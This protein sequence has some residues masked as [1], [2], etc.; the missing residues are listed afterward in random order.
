[1]AELTTFIAELGVT[2]RPT[3]LSIPLVSAPQ[4]WKDIRWNLILLVVMAVLGVA[5]QALL[6]LGPL[7]SILVTWWVEVTVWEE[8]TSSTAITTREDRTRAI[9]A[10][11]VEKLFIDTLFLSII[12][13]FSSII[14][15][16]AV[17]ANVA[18]IGRTKT[19]TCTVFTL[20]PPKLLPVVWNPLPLC[21]RW[22]K[23]PIICIPA[24]PLRIAEP[25]ALTPPRTCRKW[26]K[27]VETT[28]VMSS[29]T[30]GTSIVNIIDREG[31]RETVTTRLLTTT[32]GE[33][34]VTCS[35]TPIKPRSRAILPAIWVIN[36]LAEKWLTPVKEQPRTPWQVL[37]C[38]LVVKPID[39]PELK[40]VLYIL[41]S[42]TIS[43]S[44]ITLR[45][46]YRSPF[47]A[48]IL[49]PVW[50]TII[51]SSPGKNTLFIILMTT[52]KGLTIKQ[53]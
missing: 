21:A 52:F 4:Q 5:V 45:Y 44:F 51:V 37:R 53:G 32:L 42:T 35:S 40:Q 14:V 33:C 1:M 39:V 36:E 23:D 25:R 8:A 10:K 24:T 46:I 27:L 30:R 43:V 48:S 22:I 17:Q 47:I 13:L 18:I 12:G 15:T 20:V 38:R 31:C 41:F 3:L 19:T 9:Q 34:N 7:L 6:T 2:A 26:G 11:K 50:P 29:S 28:F 49:L 16:A